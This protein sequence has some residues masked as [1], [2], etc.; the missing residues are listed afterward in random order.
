MAGPALHRS[1]VRA[2]FAVGVAVL[3]AAC[4]GG[5]APGLGSVS[6]PTPPSFAITVD[7]T[8]H[9]VEPGTTFQQLVRSLR[10]RARAGRLLSVSG[11]VLEHGA[12]KGHIELNG[13]RHPARSSP[14]HPG[15]AIAV[16]DAKDRTEPTTRDTQ[17]TGPRLGDPE[18]TLTRYPMREVTTT[19]KISGSVESITYQPLGRPKPPAEVA[20]SFDDGPWP[21]STKRILK[22]LKRYRVPATFCM[23]GY[24][25]Q[26]YPSIAKAVQEA[27][28]TICNHSWDHP[29]DPALVALTRQHLQEELSRTNDALGAL[30]IHTTLFRPPGGS[31][32]DAV[33]QAARDQGMRV[34]MW[35]VDPQ[36]WKSN[37][38]AKKITER[39]LSKV[40]AGDIVLLHD[41]GGDAAHTIKAL[42]AIIKGIRKM[43]LKM[44][45]IPDLPAG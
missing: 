11:Q 14:L 12:F 6:S 19:G 26:R 5:A 3:F 35:S 7:G 21:V 36:D 25:I 42:P 37:L 4:S 16:L 18:F 41:G 1:R 33:A 2:A 17:A 44:V 15:D 22:I 8:T 40:R 28:M 34:L 9:A 31:E 43:G 23:V 32:N 39:V 13:D 24:E 29:L 20:L 45:A 30:G 38:N 27:G 10:L